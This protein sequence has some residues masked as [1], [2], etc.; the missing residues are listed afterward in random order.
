MPRPPRDVQYVTA[1]DLAS[2][3]PTRSRG[4]RMHNTL[5]TVMTPTTTYRLQFCSDEELEEIVRVY[6]T[7]GLL[8]VWPSSWAHPYYALVDPLFT[9]KGAGRSYLYTCPPHVHGP[10]EEKRKGLEVGASQFDIISAYAWAGMRPLPDWRSAR[11]V[12]RRARYPMPGQVGMWR[13]KWRIGH[14]CPPPH[15]RTDGEVWATSEEIEQLSLTPTYIAHG[16]VYDWTSHAVGDALKQLLDML[17]LPLWKKVARAYWGGFA[18]STGPYE[19]IPGRDVDRLLPNPRR[20]PGR[21]HFIESR[22]RLRVAEYARRAS[23]IY[24]DAVVTAEK[25]PTGTDFGA[26]A[27]K[28]EYGKAAKRVFQLTGGPPREKIQNVAGA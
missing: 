9:I 23:L 10:W 17:G 4:W 1:A 11:P 27:L 12:R 25:V 3:W 28:A 8:K 26:W 19:S 13:G 22:V 21:A 6:R 15:F 2:L 20:E 5:K 16:V 7:H 24:C 18:A 14:P